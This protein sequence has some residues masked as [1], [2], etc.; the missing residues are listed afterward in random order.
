MAI[1]VYNIMED[2]VDQNMKKIVEQ[3]PNVCYC[4]QCIA[5]ITAMALNNLKPRYVSSA[6]GGVLARVMG[7]TAVEQ[8]NLIRE[9]TSA[10]EKVAARPHH[11][12]DVK[13][14][15]NRHITITRE[16]VKE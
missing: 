12:L 9:I 16:E 7:T 4:E 14:K 5:D 1:E 15:N 3:I 6:K 2:L 11:S 13:V 10:A 8:I